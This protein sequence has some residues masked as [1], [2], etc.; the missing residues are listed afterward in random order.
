VIAKVLIG[1]TGQNSGRGEGRAARAMKTRGTNSGLGINN[2]KAGCS[3]RRQVVV[4]DFSSALFGLQQW[5][6]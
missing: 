6:H 5:S 2:H 1:G 4:A 3:S